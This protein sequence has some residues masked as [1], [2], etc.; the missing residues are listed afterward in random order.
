MQ[1]NLIPPFAPRT[2]LLNRSQPSCNPPQHN[3]TPFAAE[4]Q[5]TNFDLIPTRKSEVSL[6]YTLSTAQNS[7]LELQP[8]TFGQ[9]KVR[10]Y[11][12]DYYLRKKYH[13]TLV[14][15]HYRVSRS[16]P[17]SHSGRVPG[18]SLFFHLRRLHATEKAPPRLVFSPVCFR[19]SHHI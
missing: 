13:A 19:A 9:R 7:G 1:I 11:I 3:T 2:D 4:T 15:S 6:S 18:L 8:F 16:I 10:Q 12:P 14:S 17:L 5:C